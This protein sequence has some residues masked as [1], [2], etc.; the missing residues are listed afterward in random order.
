MCVNI[1]KFN[2]F[3]HSKVSQSLD[4]AAILASVMMMNLVFIAIKYEIHDYFQNF[5]E[6]APWLEC[7]ECL[8]PAA[9]QNIV[10]GGLGC[11]LEKASVC[12]IAKR[13]RARKI[14]FSFTSATLL[15]KSVPLHS[16]NVWK[17][18][19]TYSQ[20]QGTVQPI[21]FRSFWGLYRLWG[22]QDPCD[23]N[24]AYHTST[25]ACGRNLLGWWTVPFT[26]VSPIDVL[27]GRGATHCIDD[28]TTKS[29]FSSVTIQGFQKW[30]LRLNNYRG[31]F[32]IR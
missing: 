26:T 31:S 17:W 25:W 16:G 19:L 4:P 9:Q 10:V 27:H 24:E 5:L 22:F 14:N 30:Q 20:L 18:S 21:K 23:Q 6:I 12:L 32:E 2:M 29:N 28:P 15:T 8:L 7:S 11:Y 1:S 13:L 3:Q